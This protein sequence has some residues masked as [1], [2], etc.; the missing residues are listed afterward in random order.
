MKG[1]DILRAMNGIDDRFIISAGRE[2]A[3]RRGRII[4]LPMKIAAGI[5]AAIV[6]AVP[7]GAAYSKFIHESSVREYFTEE[8]AEYL[9][10]NGYALN[11][12]DENEHVRVTID[13]L[14]S[15]GHNGNMIMTVDALDEEGQELVNRNGRR[16]PVPVASGED[17]EEIML[18]GGGAIHEQSSE[19]S[20]GIQTD[21]QFDFSGIDITREYTVRFVS[22]ETEYDAD[23]DTYETPWVSG[24]FEG[25]EFT[26][27]FAPNVD[28]AEFTDT[29]GDSITVSQIGYY[30]DELAVSEKL[31]TKNNNDDITFY[32]K[33]SPLGDKA[34]VVSASYDRS[35]ETPYSYALFDSIVDIKEYDSIEISG[36]KFTLE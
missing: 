8:S 25:I 31:G 18:M 6:L 20:Y 16:M 35:H 26:L 30:S 33:F 7:A 23:K 5:A 29:D 1:N 3:V 17:G 21:M 10:E 24:V 32:K 14:L 11:L 12:V 15:D 36:Y 27:C 28:T 4:K 2:R 34:D 22:Y 9:D 13:T 19:T